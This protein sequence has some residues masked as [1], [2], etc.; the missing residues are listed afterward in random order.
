MFPA[1]PCW[2]DESISDQ[3]QSRVDLRLTPYVWTEARGT[4]LERDGSLERERERSM[5]AYPPR[6]VLT[7]ALGSAWSLTYCSTSAAYLRSSAG[8]RDNERMFPAPPRPAWVT[9]TTSNHQLGQDINVQRLGRT[10][11]PMV[12]SSRPREGEKSSGPFPRGAGSREAGRILP[13]E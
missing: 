10:A 7:G 11:V 8:S 1:P 2:S 12:G 9:Y 13:V 4:S 6:P 3:Q 5:L